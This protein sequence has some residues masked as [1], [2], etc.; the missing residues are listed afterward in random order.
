MEQHGGNIHLI[1]RQKKSSEQ[2]IIDFSAS[3]NPFGP[4]ASV[5]G[6]I[7]RAIGDI[8]HYP[9]P[10][11]YELKNVLAGRYRVEKDQIVIANGTTEIL[12]TLFR[13]YKP[14]RVF[15]PVPSYVDYLAAVKREK[16]PYTLLYLDEKENF[17]IDLDRLQQQLKPD[18]L[19]ILGSP[20]NP[21]GLY[22]PQKELLHLAD[23]RKD[24]SFLVDES[25]L[26][27]VETGESVAGVRDNVFTLNSLTKFYA[28]P[29]LRLGFGIFPS[30]LALTLKSN[31]P[32]W[33]VNSLAQTVG[34][35]CIND[36]FFTAHTHEKLKT[37]KDV[38]FKQLEKFDQISLFPTDV[39]F[40]LGKVEDKAVD[41]H[42][43]LLKRN[44]L[45]RN[46]HN[47]KGL[48]N[49]YYRWA[50]KTPDENQLMIDALEDVF[51]GPLKK[52]QRKKAAT[53]MFQG[54][55]SNAGKSIL[56]TALCRILLEDGVR[57]APFKSQNMSLNSFVTAG[58]GEMGRAQV[59]QAQAAKL[60][61]DVRM[62][63]VLL[64]PNS[65]TGSQ[66][67][68]KGKPVANMDVWQYSRFKKQAWCDVTAC[69]NSLSDEFDAIVLEGAGSPG[70]INLKQDDIVN[71][72]MAEY[73]KSP[74]LLVGDID[75]GGVYA[76]FIGTME[77]LDEWERNLLK[78]FV[79]NKFRGN[80]DLLASAHQQLLH[81]TGK[82]VYGV[83]PY[84][85]NLSI[86]EE[87]SVS[88]KEGYIEN[89]KPDQPYIDLAVIDLPHI[90]N[91]TDIEP[92][93]NE[94]DVYVRIVGTAQQL[95]R[96]DVIIIP[97]SKNVFNDLEYLKSSG[98]AENLLRCAEQGVEIIGICGGYM[99]LGC[100]IAD[101]HSVESH[102]GKKEGLGLL[103]IHT[104]L[105]KNKQLVRKKGVYLPAQMTIKGYEIHHGQT[106]TD[107]QPLFQFDDG[108]C[109]GCSAADR[110]VWGAFLHG[111]F[112]DDQFRRWFIDKKR[113]QKGWDA[114]QKVL[115]PYD[116]E[117]S[118]DTLAMVVR[119]SL[120]MDKIYAIMGL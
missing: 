91:F 9:D 94:P 115:A 61:P 117:A 52:R 107:L 58:G 31:I 47:F 110:S 1:R 114:K 21:T 12:F 109:C 62:N 81:R 39:N 84:L 79:V 90:S 22:V 83:V 104:V 70:E 17:R 111:M 103:A 4:P 108:S 15:I 46:C 73:A 24:V 82:S 18:D 11:C 51:A 80:Q 45:I 85:K 34:V 101:P 75:R 95:G 32:V 8:I 64:K 67:I 113:R 72:R 37:T 86:P 7:S 38:F 27:F 48:G 3:I 29:G 44:I 55:C 40:I 41:L 74:V 68:V 76:S 100:F 112:D 5:R 88:F 69:F 99:M 93:Y 97:G 96:P 106:Q 28:I 20:N 30:E 57:V 118:F 53:I 43:A 2:E 98:L 63:P 19:V 102:V 10:D 36:D 33:S 105:D 59:V 116:I 71:M 89:S 120:E 49:S 14:A 23:V 60:D 6:E 65:D 35:A 25:F 26:D 13:G 54:T 119:E 92:F 50:V 16:I 78:G 87:D 66:I 42:S 77:V 56:A